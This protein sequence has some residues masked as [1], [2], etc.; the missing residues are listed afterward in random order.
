MIDSGNIIHIME[1]ECPYCGKSC[2]ALKNHVRLASGD[3]HGSSG[4]YP[5]DFNGGQRGESTDSVDSVNSESG[6][7]SVTSTVEFPTAEGVEDSS[8]PPR[9]SAAGQG[10]S[11]GSL[12]ECPRCGSELI[13]GEQLIEE[14][15]QIMRSPDREGQDVL[16]RQLL[17]LNRG[18]NVEKACCEAWNCGF[19]VNAAGEKREK[20]KKKESQGFFSRLLG[21]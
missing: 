4:E 14:M 16:A 15:Q 7:D 13:S 1:K 18:A 8:G 9:E 6:G 20:K 3:G 21:A 17:E 11:S 12:D 10:N 2:N 19:F 5:P